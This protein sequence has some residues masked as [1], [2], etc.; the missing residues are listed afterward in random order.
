[1]HTSNISFPHNLLTS[2]G[3]EIYGQK[4]EQKRLSH[5]ELILYTICKE[6]I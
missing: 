2:F 6:L 3:K 5:Y 4:C 1:M